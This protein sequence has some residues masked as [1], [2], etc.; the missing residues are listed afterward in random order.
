M[1]DGEPSQKDG[2][3]VGP[4]ISR[5]CVYLTLIIVSLGF[6]LLGKALVW[7]FAW[8]I[9]ASFIIPGVV[10]LL[11][12]LSLAQPGSPKHVVLMG[13]AGAVAG[14]LA[15]IGYAALSLVTQSFPAHLLG[16]GMASGVAFLAVHWLL[17]LLGVP[18]RP[19]RSDSPPNGTAPSGSGR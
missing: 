4:T 11:V 13:V 5:W 18:R 7:L 19:A 10:A 17:G 3:D 6:G 16:I 8:P 1:S 14:I 9:G 12:T 2:G 15:I